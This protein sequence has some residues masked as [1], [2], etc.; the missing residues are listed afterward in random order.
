MTTGDGTSAGGATA[1]AAPEASGTD[2]TQYDTGGGA[3]AFLNTADMATM[4][5]HLDRMSY[6]QAEQVLRNQR[7][8]LRDEPE[9]SLLDLLQRQSGSGSR[10]VQLSMVLDELMRETQR[11]DML[12]LAVVR[13]AKELHTRGELDTLPIDRRYREGMV[14]TLAK[15]LRNWTIK[16]P[17]IQRIGE[18]WGPDWWQKLKVA[19]EVETSGLTDAE[20]L[21]GGILHEIAAVACDPAYRNDQAGAMGKWRDAIALRCN[22][23]LRALNNVGRIDSRRVLRPM[24]IRSACTEASSRVEERESELDEDPSAILP[25]LVIQQTTATTLIQNDDDNDTGGNSNKRKHRGQQRGRRRKVVSAAVISDSDGEDDCDGGDNNNDDDDGEQSTAAADEAEARRMG[26]SLSNDGDMEGS[27]CASSLLSA[28]VLAFLRR[29]EELSGNCSCGPCTDTG[30]GGEIAEAVRTSRLRE[31]AEA[32]N[33]G[34][35]HGLR[36]NPRRQQQQ[37]LQGS[38]AR[39]QL[40]AASISDTD[41]FEVLTDPDGLESQQTE[42]GESSPEPVGGVPEQQQSAAAD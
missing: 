7:G 14:A 2:R 11:T 40:R 34:G 10:S 1:A 37:L 8:L 35:R 21:T 27:W 19:L 9:A 4:Q 25:P 3:L 13:Y 18:A 36:Q 20:E 17:L 5:P 23:Q 24:D 15:G 28:E 39:P 30:L 38:A 22:V 31:L 6:A 26:A 16:V 32:L 29:V 33:Q 12:V 42:V 41:R